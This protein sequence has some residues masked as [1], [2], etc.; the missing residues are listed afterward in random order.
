M[1]AKEKIYYLIQQYHNNKYT[2][3]DF[4]DQFS[5]IYEKENIVDLTEHEKSLF[6]ALE[7]ITCRFSPNQEYHEGYPIYTTEKDVKELAEVIYM[8]LFYL[9]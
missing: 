7:E 8:E 1:T 9:K 2:T 6:S 4:A 3:L 5:I